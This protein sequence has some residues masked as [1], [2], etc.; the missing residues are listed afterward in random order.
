[1]AATQTNHLTV[2]IGYFEEP[3]PGV[4]VG[5]SGWYHSNGQ[6]PIRS[7][8]DVFTCDTSASNPLLRPGI[9]GPFTAQAMALE[10]LE[11]ATKKP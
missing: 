6:F 5:F 7:A 8:G 3:E 9:T 1:M 10:N 4:P 2:F 11:A